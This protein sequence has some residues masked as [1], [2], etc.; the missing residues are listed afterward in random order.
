MQRLATRI[1]YKEAG[2][3]SR[4]S[5]QRLMESE[6]LSGLA[7]AWRLWAVCNELTAGYSKSADRI[8]VVTLA[9]LAGIRADKASRLLRDFD[10]LGIF[11]WRKDA[12]RKSPG[13]LALPSWVEPDGKPKPERK[14]KCPEC[15]STDVA[16]HTSDLYGV[17]WV[18]LDC[19]HTEQQWSLEEG[20]GQAP[21]WA[22][23]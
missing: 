9:N 14:P 4:L 17:S 15:S 19:S 5:R 12:G 13:F 7:R 10:R 18:C 23:N 11:I 21:D 3:R 6:E 20:L 16:R 2:R 8:H 1:D 22:S